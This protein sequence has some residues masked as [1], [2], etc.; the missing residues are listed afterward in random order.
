MRCFYSWTH[1][2]EK[3]RD[4]MFF[5]EPLREIILKHILTTLTERFKLFRLILQWRRQEFMSGWSEAELGEAGRSEAKRL[6]CTYT[7]WIG[8]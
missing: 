1:R 7:R 2:S 5:I 4:R 8:R 3:L 6:L